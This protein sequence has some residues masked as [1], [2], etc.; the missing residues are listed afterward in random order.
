MSTDSTSV[1]GPNGRGQ[2]L[3]LVIPTGSFGSLFKMLEGAF[4]A[5]NRPVNPVK[6]NSMAQDWMDPIA[7][8][9]TLV[10]CRDGA[11]DYYYIIDGQHRLSAASLRGGVTLSCAIYEEE[12][13]PYEDVKKWI[14][15]L[16]TLKTIFR[17][18]DYLM[19]H[20]SDSVWP[21]VFE[22]SDVPPAYANSQSALTW[23]T[24]VRGF[25]V[26]RYIY[27]KQAITDGPYF[28]PGRYIN[29]WTKTPKEQVDEMQ[30]W[31]EWWRPFTE[32]AGV[33]NIKAASSYRAAA[34]SIALWLENKDVRPEQLARVPERMLRFPEIN[35]LHYHTA[36]RDLAPTFLKGANYKCSSNL[37]TIAGSTGRVD[38]LFDDAEDWS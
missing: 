19:T 1:P 21:T 29:L 37:L 15:Y 38:A 30:K 13:L 23:V 20:S 26:G 36:L 33:R 8:L 24:V 17:T 34:L 2:K 5:H 7:G 9:V 28:K 22:Q 6:R 12:D 16:N 10:R 31:Y 18:V 35:T 14:T 11:V 25:G 32:E 27:R 3:D 4:G